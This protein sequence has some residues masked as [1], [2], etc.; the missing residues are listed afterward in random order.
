MG[1]A[2][3]SASF[4][5]Y[6]ISGSGP[7]D[8]TDAFVQTVQEHAFGRYGTVATDGTEI[9][10]ITPRHLFDTEIRPEY[11]AVG[12]FASLA[13]RMDR[14]AVP[15]A[16]LKSYVLVEEDAALQASGREFLSKSDR[17][18]A[19]EAAQLRADREA[20][21]GAFRRMAAYPLVIDLEHQTVYFG[22]LAD[23]VND[24]MVG[25]FEDTFECRL[26]PASAERVAYR[27][28]EAAGTTEGIEHAKP[29]HLVPAP[30]G[31]EGAPD[32]FDTGDRC[33]LGKEF[34]TWLW[35]KIDSDRSALQ[36]NTGDELAV[37][38]SRTMK[39]ECDFAVNGT[40]VITAD[41]PASLPEAKA[42]LST[43]KQVTRMGL[44]LGCR[45]GEYSL[46]LDGRRMAISTMIPPTDD[47]E[48]DPQARREQ[49]FEQIA[50]AAELLDVLFELFLRRRT[51]GEWSQELGR[52]R[53]WAANGNAVPG[54]RAAS[55]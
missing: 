10:W 29:F 35:Y 36:L 48:R 42:A 32:D 53:S 49:R 16:V 3:G 27:L 45:T 17:A 39:L 15:S 55:A 7:A 28:M 33:F 4:R 41:G 34:L 11:L 38:I 50:D 26:E 13:V 44:I 21:N 37:M 6:F 25:L 9:G 23:K 43:G 22:N 1:L 51:S 31:Y 2:A 52:M 18:K 20:K 24:R 30:D 46:V 14:T 40:D 19:R 47:E 54:A 5:R 12:R 8:V